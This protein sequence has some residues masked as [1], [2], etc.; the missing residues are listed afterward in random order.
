MVGDRVDIVPNHACA[1]ANLHRQ[2]L[3]IERD[4]LVDLWQI[5]AAG[6]GG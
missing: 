6:P 3:V 4:E 2:A 1:A 5:G